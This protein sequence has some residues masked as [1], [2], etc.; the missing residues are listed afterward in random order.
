VLET[1][2]AK[3]AAILT[4]ACL[5]HTVSGCGRL[6]QS[7]ADA[8]S[9][10]A[11]REKD[12]PAAPTPALPRC[13]S[14]PITMLQASAPGTGH[15]K[16]FLAW[17]ASTSSGQPGASAIGYCL[18]RSQKK[19]N[20]KKFPKCPDCEQV[21]L[22]PVV[23]SRCVDDLVRDQTKYYYVAIAINSGNGISSPTDEAV[24][25]IPAAGKQNAAPPDAASYPACR[26]LASSNQ[27]PRQ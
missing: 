8:Q 10:P 21:S 16:V 17:N 15:H 6:S 5:V 11:K 3:I 14:A 19:G 27:P 1:M 2:S 7:R 23:S 13:P 12:I 22:S 20:A 4:I 9:A 18:Y 26:A 25:E 24:A